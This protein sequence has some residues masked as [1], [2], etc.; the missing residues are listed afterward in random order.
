MVDDVD[1]QSCDVDIF[2]LHGRENKTK[3]WSNKYKNQMKI[4]EWAINMDN[5]RMDTA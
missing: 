1:T 3:I 5:I 4:I 2:S